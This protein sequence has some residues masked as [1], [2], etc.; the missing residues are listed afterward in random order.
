MKKYEIE[1]DGQVYHV[2]VRELPDDAVMTEQPKADS[3]KSTAD[4][5]PQT[6]GKA[7]LAPMAGTVLRILVKEG[8]R[9]KKG[10]N[11]IVLEAMKME[12][13]IVADEDGVV[14]RILVKENDSVESDQALLIL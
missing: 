11:L 4:V 6:E 14:R 2:K 7:M 5:A 8:Q 9:V 1:I 3:G 10:E 12:N 13:E